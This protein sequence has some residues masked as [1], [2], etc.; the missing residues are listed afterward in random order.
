MTRCKV[1][2]LVAA[3]QRAVNSPARKEVDEAIAAEAV[4]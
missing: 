1:V 4:R 3:I 2:M